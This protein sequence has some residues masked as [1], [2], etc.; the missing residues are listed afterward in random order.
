MVCFY[1]NAGCWILQLIY[2]YIYI[3]ISICK[4]SKLKIKELIFKKF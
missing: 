2:I 4:E 3:Y 1:V